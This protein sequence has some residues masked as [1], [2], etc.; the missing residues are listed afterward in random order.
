MGILIEIN[1]TSLNELQ[2]AISFIIVVYCAKT[3]KI[4]ARGTCTFAGS[5]K[6]LGAFF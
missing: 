5:H 1:I 2:V 4:L 3:F 6:W